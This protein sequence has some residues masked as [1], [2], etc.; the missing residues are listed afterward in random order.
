[1]NTEYLKCKIKYHYFSF[2]I[3]VS[4]YLLPQSLKVFGDYQGR[5]LVFEIA[6]T[7][8]QTV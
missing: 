3:N 4:L 2:Q 8:Q 6:I 5:L 7:F 1:M